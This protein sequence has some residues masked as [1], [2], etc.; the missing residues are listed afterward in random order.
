MLSS[1]LFCVAIRIS[2]TPS[3][4]LVGSY[5]P[6]RGIPAA[7]SQEALRPPDL[8]ALIVTEDIV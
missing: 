3:Y 2:L 1:T 4:G 8:A 5:G 6:G 7:G